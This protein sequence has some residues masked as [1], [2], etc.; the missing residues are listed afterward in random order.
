MKGAQGDSLMLHYIAEQE[1]LDQHA[2]KYPSDATRIL[3][4]ELG[5]VL[6]CFEDAAGKQY[7]LNVLAIAPH[8]HLIAPPRHLEY[9]IDTREDMDSAI[10][11]CTIGLV[12][13]ALTAGFLLTNGLWLLCALVPYSVSYLAYKGAVSAAQ[14]YGSVVA[15]VIDLDRFLLY[16]ELGLSRPRDS[17]EELESNSKLMQILSGE[18][19]SVRYRRE[20]T[21]SGPSARA[22]RRGRKP[23]A[24]RLT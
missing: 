22:E 1:A 3:P 18:H 16:N 19:V 5:N 14:G 8:L 13:T 2:N 21:T 17:E 7:G 12:A 15:S 10:R 24:N 23:G 9:L 11:I 4:T 20:N 6:R